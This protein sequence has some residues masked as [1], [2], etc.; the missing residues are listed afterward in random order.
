MYVDALILRDRDSDGDGTPDQRLWVVQD[1]NYNVTAL[2]DNAGNVV[3]RY[4]YDP[5]GQATVLDFSYIVQSSG[6]S[7][8][9]H[10]G[11][12][13]LRYDSTTGLSFT[14]TRPYS[15]NLGRFTVHDWIGFQGG[16]VN[17]Y[18]LVGNMPINATDPTGQT[19]FIS[20]RDVGIWKEKFGS[21]INL[22]QVRNGLYRADVTAA[23][24]ATNKFYNEV[25]NYLQS[26]NIVGEGDVVAQALT[27]LFDG[28]VREPSPAYR[29]HMDRVLDCPLENGGRLG[30]YRLMPLS[31]Y[32]LEGL[33]LNNLPVVLPAIAKSDATKTK[34]A[35]I[36]LAIANTFNR[37]S[38]ISLRLFTEQNKGYWCYEWAYAFEDAFK[39]ESSGKY[40]KATIEG[41]AGKGDVVHFWLRIDS[42]ETGMSIFVDDGFMNGSY[43]HDKR[44]AHGIYQYTP[45]LLHDI[46]RTKWLQIPRA[47]DRNNRPIP[48]PIPNLPPLLDGLMPLSTW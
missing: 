34:A 20:A 42:L 33:H 14:H 40:F 7:Y 1:A 45:G 12:Q 29:S 15:P 9:F 3:E 28:G 39:Y 5:F 31:A 10:Y 11:F 43:I 13:G 36:G 21:Y 48:I 27:S 46:P 8:D 47:Y 22:V 30:S 23:G 6:S 19:L 4:V 37:N 17:L 16:D 32:G 41:A 26:L 2:F 18:R 38:R 35:A 25:T 44:P 24:R